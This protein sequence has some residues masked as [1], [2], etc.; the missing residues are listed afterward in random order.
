LVRLI[1]E[2]KHNMDTNILINSSWNDKA[3]AKYRTYILSILGDNEN[4]EWEQRIVNTNLPCCAKSCS[5]ARQIASKIMKGNY[6]EF[7][8]KINFENHVDTIVY[9]YILNQ[10]KDFDLFEK[11]L[12]SFVI[13][14]DNWASCD[15][16]KHKK[17]DKLRLL[18]LCHKLLN[19]S[20][21]FAR[22]VGVNICFDLVCEEF[23]EEIFQILDGLK[24]EQEYYVNMSGAWLLCECFV[25]YR[26]RTKEYFVNNNTNDFIINKAISK[27]RD[28]FRVSKEDKELL[29]KYRR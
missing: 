6:Y 10:I 7:L 23:L 13:R 8:D 9:G 16:L 21:L 18:E 25:K 26:D 5:K 1:K 15:V 29:K 27:C 4:C 19:N 22:R 3:F 11:Y 24:E 12:M 20:Y 14:I 17:R 28:S 2:D